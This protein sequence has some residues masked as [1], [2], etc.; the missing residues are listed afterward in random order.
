MRFK[1]PY[2][3]YSLHFLALLLFV[4]IFIDPS[5]KEKKAVYKKTNIFLM[6]D[7]NVLNSPYRE[8]VL[9]LSE[10]IK[11]WSDE[12]YINLHFLKVRPDISETESTSLNEVSFW[13]HS[14]QFQNKAN[15]FIQQKLQRKENIVLYF[16]DYQSEHPRFFNLLGI[17]NRASAASD[18]ILLRDRSDSNSIDLRF[19]SPQ[20]ER[21]YSFKYH[22]PGTKTSKK[23]LSSTSDRENLLD[24]NIQ[25]EKDSYYLLLENEQPGYRQLFIKKDRALKHRILTYSITADNGRLYRSLSGQGNNSVMLEYQFRNK[26]IPGEKS[27]D[28]IWLIQAD[29][30]TLQ[31]VQGW[32][33][34]IIHL[35]NGLNGGRNYQPT[36]HGDLYYLRQIQS[37]RLNAVPVSNIEKAL[38]FHE[39]SAK[40]SI[41]FQAENYTYLGIKSFSSL[42]PLS[43]RASEIETLRA[44]ID[45]LYKPYAREAQL[46]SMP[47]HQ[48]EINHVL[49]KPVEWKQDFRAR[50]WLLNKR[51]LRDD[52]Y[53]FSI[54]DYQSGL[55]RLEKI[56][57][58]GNSVQQYFFYL[59]VPRSMASQAVLK[60]SSVDSQAV[61]RFLNRQTE[62][63]ESNSI[64]IRKKW[65]D[66]YWFFPVLLLF[67]LIAFY[68]RTQ[69]Q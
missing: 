56:D 39:G 18:L 66:A 60:T 13:S 69:K 23:T 7:N 15:N 54:R 20:P 25:W 27:A 2:F 40:S 28:I 6:I 53:M 11:S 52:Q 8:E 14:G 17:S 47:V 44:F 26:T 34:P 4:L 12:Q 35:E 16:G 22:F 38:H 50:D 67:S 19:R 24:L 43:T 65:I 49:H 58:N 62:N 31:E 41:A 9:K 36:W 1:K 29:K 48:K 37:G 63:I 51:P 42:F 61:L 3:V 57:K 45:L 21:S 32:G 46:K 30:S 33:K 64:Y 55:N 5:V 10:S 59:N 68:F